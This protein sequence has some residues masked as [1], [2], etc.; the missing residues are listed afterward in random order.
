S[1]VAALSYLSKQNYIDASSVDEPHL[2]PMPARVRN[3]VLSTPSVYAFKV[4][5]AI[6]CLT[7]ILYNQPLLFQRWYMN[8]AL[9]TTLI[10]ISP[11]LGQ[12][13]FFLPVQ[14]LATSIGAAFA[15]SGVVVVGDSH[16]G[17]LGF[18]C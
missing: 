5:T 1:I 11:S 10:A 17:I 3:L 9:V 13:Y 6:V 14:I 4:G 15:C 16:F 7:M 2:L 12:Q 18:A 8:G